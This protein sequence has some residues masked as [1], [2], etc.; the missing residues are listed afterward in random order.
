[1]P[2]DINGGISQKDLQPQASRSVAQDDQVCVS[3]S[4][5][6]QVLLFLGTLHMLASHIMA[7][8]LE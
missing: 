7:M 4:G 8:S 1:M 6:L 5:V 3:V 2:N